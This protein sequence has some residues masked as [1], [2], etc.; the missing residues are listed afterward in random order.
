MLGSSSPS[1]PHR[2]PFPCQ[3]LL[4]QKVSDPTCSSPGFL[5]AMHGNS[6][7]LVASG[8]GGGVCVWG[9]HKPK[10]PL[11]SFSNPPPHLVYKET[12][13]I[14]PSKW[15]QNQNTSHQI[16]SHPMASWD[17]NHL[18]PGPSS[19]CPPWAHC[20]SPCPLPVPHVAAGCHLQQLTSLA[21]GS[22]TKAKSSPWL[23]RPD[24]I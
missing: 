6:V 8:S 20:Q 7:P 21:P 14:L 13:T 12:L 16:H 22:S 9:E 3:A 15:V 17:S 5:I 4:T 11:L 19:Q 1:P 10:P 24:T 2:A 23:T 18:L